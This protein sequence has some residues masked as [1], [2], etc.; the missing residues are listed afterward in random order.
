VNEPPRRE[1][2]PVG[3]FSAGTKLAP[4]AG[5]V[6]VAVLSVGI[7]RAEEAD[8]RQGLWQFER[9]VGGR[10]LQT[11]EC[12][13][14][15]DDMDRQ[16]AMLAK[17]GCKFSPPQRVG[18][19][20]TFSAECAVKPPGGETVTAHSTSVMT[21]Q[22]DSAYT[23]DITTTGAGTTTQERLVARRIGDCVK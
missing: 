19:T 1:D 21:V 14:P 4:V 16:N 2:T 12:T 22:S 6:A 13:D 18:S 11:Q 9:T 15:N 10:K 5:V 7:A 20:Y 17:S 3:R 8:L 23:V